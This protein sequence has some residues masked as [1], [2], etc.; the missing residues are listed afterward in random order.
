MNRK[1]RPHHDLE[2]GIIPT[3]EA[4]ISPTTSLANTQMT[5][6]LAKTPSNSNGF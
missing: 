3:P 4:R 6:H 2:I 5:P 1:A